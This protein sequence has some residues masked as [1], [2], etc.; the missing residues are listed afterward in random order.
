MK[1]VSFAPTHSRYAAADSGTACNLCAPLRRTNYEWLSLLYCAS[2]GRGRH[3]LSPWQISW[4]ASLTSQTHPALLELSSGK[5]FQL[6][7]QPAKPV[8]LTTLLVCSSQDVVDSLRPLEFHVGGMRMSQSINE[9]E[10]NRE[11]S[12]KAT[13]EAASTQRSSDTRT[14]MWCS[15]QYQL[16]KFSITVYSSASKSASQALS[17]QK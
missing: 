17:P 12:A 8:A 4:A 5:L 14:G 15:S 3:A 2:L 11:A 16:Q 6:Q 10:L 1:S 13:A 7:E 9:Q